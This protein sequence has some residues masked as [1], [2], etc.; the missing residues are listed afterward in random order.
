[1]QRGLLV[2]FSCNPHSLL[3]SPLESF[4]GCED[5][6]S[7]SDEWLLQHA[8]LKSDC[9]LLL[10]IRVQLVVSCTTIEVQVVFE[11]LLTLATSQLAVAGQCQAWFT[12]GW[13][14]AEWTR[15]WADLWNNPG[16]SL[17][18]ALSICHV[19]ATSDEGE[20]VRVGVST[21]WCVAVE[22]QRSSS[23]RGY[24]HWLSD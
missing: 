17:C 19:V 14:S 8:A 13:K 16:F 9:S 12:P 4:A 23:I 15:R 6:L 18:A 10:R 2:E 22:H 11:M 3:D 20:K 24:L 5:H 21:D 7:L 1:M